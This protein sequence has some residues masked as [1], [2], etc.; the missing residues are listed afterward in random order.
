M[1]GRY[2]FTSPLE[3]IQ[4]MFKFDQNLNTTAPLHAATAAMVAR[5]TV[6]HGGEMASRL[7]LPVLPAGAL[8]ALAVDL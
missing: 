3:A 4:E 6:F 8:E 1:C 7:R 2:L 5:Q